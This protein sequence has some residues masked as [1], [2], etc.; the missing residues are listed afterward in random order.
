MS[1][2][3][4]CSTPTSP[5]AIGAMLRAYKQTVEEQSGKPFPQ[6]WH[7]QLWRAVG[8]VFSSL[9][10]ARAITYRRLNAISGSLG[11]GRRCRRWCS[12]TWARRR[13]DGQG[14]ARPRQGALRRHGGGC[15]GER[16]RD[17]LHGGHDDRASADGPDGGQNRRIGGL[18]LRNQRPHPDGVRHQPRRRFLV[19]RLL[20]A[21]GID[22]RR[23]L[24]DAGPGR[25]RPAS[26]DGGRA[27][28]GSEAGHQARHLQGARRRLCLHPLL[29]GGRARL[30]LLLALPR[31]TPPH[32]HPSP[33]GMG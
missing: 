27:R 26:H 24:H 28:A 31:A 9:M 30:H 13:P 16:R 19:P 5:P 15:Q 32:R 6:D 33:A 25:R 2:R 3:V 21:Q 17:P 29:R 1:A 4:P 23:P 11:H 22:A 14:R 10:N 12:A 8:A 18:L 20:H 7:E